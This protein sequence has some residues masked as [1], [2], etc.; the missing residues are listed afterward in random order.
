MNVGQSTRFM[1]LAD[2]NTSPPS[3]GIAQLACPL[4]FPFYLL[5]LICRVKREG[6]KQ[7]NNAAICSFLHGA[8]HFS[9]FIFHAEKWGRISHLVN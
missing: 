1:P 2:A 6:K 7:T 5:D 8:T 9:R 4:A 3:N